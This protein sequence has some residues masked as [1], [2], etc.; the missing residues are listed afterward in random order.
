MFEPEPQDDRLMSLNTENT[1]GGL[2]AELAT[3]V[4]RERSAALGNGSLTIEEIVREILR[5]LLKTWLDENLPGMTERLVQK[6]IERLV[7]R[8]EKL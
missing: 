8:S 6:E 4:A 1:A 7:A 5:E 2:L 3:A